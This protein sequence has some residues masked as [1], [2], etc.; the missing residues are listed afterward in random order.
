MWTHTF[1]YWKRHAINRYWQS[2]MQIIGQCGCCD[3]EFYATPT[4][5]NPLRFSHSSRQKHFKGFHHRSPQTSLH[6]RKA[7]CQETMTAGSQLSTN[8][9]S[10]LEV[11]VRP[12]VKCQSF[13]GRLLGRIEWK[14]REDVWVCTFCGWLSVSAQMSSKTLSQ[15]SPP[16]TRVVVHILAAWLF[17]YL[18]WIFAGAYRAPEP[19]TSPLKTRWNKRRQ[20]TFQQFSLFLELWI[21]HMLCKIILV[22]W[23]V[24]GLFVKSSRRINTAIPALKPQSIFSWICMIKNNQ[25]LVFRGMIARGIHHRL[26]FTAHA[27]ALSTTA[28][29]AASYT[30]FRIH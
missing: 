19:P 8:D 2:S 25:T 14:G 9:A 20:T 21:P 6:L 15:H 10:R 16:E 26:L 30:G 11:W 22:I 23:K 28:W 17:M 1:F 4:L 27:N 24:W 29:S 3:L 18:T 7:S 13:Q 5:N 12:S